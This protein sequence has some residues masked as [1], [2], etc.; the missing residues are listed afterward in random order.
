MAKKPESTTRTNPPA[1]E[2]Q[3]SGG[4]L[5]GNIRTLGIIGLVLLALVGVVAYVMI[6]SAKENDRAQLELARIRPYYDRGEFAVAGNG[7]SSKT[8]GGEKIH[9]LL[10]IVNEWGSTASGKIAA[11]YLGNSYVALGQ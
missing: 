5:L 3:A 10:Y 6:N 1:S 9:G 4:F 7:D 11:L 8:Y 2:R